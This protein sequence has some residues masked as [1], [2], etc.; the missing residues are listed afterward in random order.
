MAQKTQE[1]DKEGVLRMQR[2]VQQSEDVGIATNVKLKTQT[3]QLKNIGVDVA[4]VNAR[5]KDA[6]KLLN[7]I[8]RRMETDKFL[9][10]FIGAFE[11]WR[12]GWWG[13]L[14]AQCLTIFGAAKC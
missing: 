14:H 2:M 7:Q 11:R 8:G 6:N 1:E 4:N 9:M 12:V 3:E 13:V 5:M 10:F